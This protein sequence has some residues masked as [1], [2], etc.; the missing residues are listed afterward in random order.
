MGSAGAA[1]RREGGLLAGSVLTLRLGLVGLRPR[2]DAEVSGS[3]SRGAR[4]GELWP[5]QRSEA[6]HGVIPLLDGGGA[7]CD[8][9]VRSHRHHSGL[10]GKPRAGGRRASRARRQQRSLSRA[11]HRRE[12]L[13]DAKKQKQLRKRERE[14]RMGT[15]ARQTK[16][17]WRPGK[18]PTPFRELARGVG[19]GWGWGERLFSTEE[20]ARIVRGVTARYSHED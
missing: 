5:R 16:G 3:P 6:R 8:Y 17:T 9:P 15:D 1:E 10:G 20:R 12:G 14:R 11:N 13:T 18:R 19:W 7:W 4:F 2:L